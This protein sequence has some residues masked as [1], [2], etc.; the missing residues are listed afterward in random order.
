MR[1]VSSRFFTAPPRRFAASRN[2]FASFSCIVLP[3]PRARR[4]ADE[5]ADAEREAAVRVHFDRHLVV[6]AADAARLHLEARLDVVDRLLEDLQRI[7]AGLLLDD[8]EALVE[9]ALGRAAL[10]VAHHAVDELG[11]ERALIERV[12]RRCRAWEFLV[13]AAYVFSLTFLK[14]SSGAS[15]RTSNVPA[16]GPATPTA[17][18]VPRTT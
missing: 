6:R 18:S 3:S 11:D 13:Y 15:R 4:V 14:P 2:S 1:C 10:A 16:S 12:R 8:V 5:P 7:V 17:S 9:D